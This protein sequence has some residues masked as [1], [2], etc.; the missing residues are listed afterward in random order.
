[1]R[2]EWHDTLGRHCPRFGVSREVVLPIPR[3]VGFSSNEAYKLALMV[4]KERYTTPWLLVFGLPSGK[5]PMVDITL[6]HFVGELRGVSAKVVTMPDEFIVKHPSVSSHYHNM[7]H[8]PKHLLLRYTWKEQAEVDVPAGL[9][10]LFGTGFILTTVLALFI[11]QSSK[12]KITKFVNQ[13]MV[14]TSTAVSPGEVAKI[15]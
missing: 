7:T 13:Q 11:L 3:P 1:M 8:W 6:T 15:D 10:V 14:E 12:E 4:G 5:V 2:T 9:F